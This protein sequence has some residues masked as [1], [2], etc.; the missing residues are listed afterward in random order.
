MTELDTIREVVAQVE[1]PL[2]RGLGHRGLMASFVDSELRLGMTI[3]GPVTA[4]LQRILD[5]KGVETTRVRK[6]MTIRSGGFRPDTVDHVVLRHGEVTIDPTYTQFYDRIGL[7]SYAANKNPA[8][9]AILPTPKIAVFEDTELYHF[10]A[11]LTDNILHSRPEAL[12][13]S[14]EQYVE[15]TNK[16]PNTLVVER[17]PLFENA[18]PKHILYYFYSLYGTR[19]YELFP[20][21]ESDV[22]YKK[23]V[24]DIA[25]QVID[26]IS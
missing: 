23:V 20:F 14:R 15:A 22:A 19:G 5:H 18:G 16:S 4:C 21:D 10:S 1:E 17:I 13:L 24:H 9:K 2:S 11:T 25:D 8:M 6:K 7:S 3:C 26:E 12:Q